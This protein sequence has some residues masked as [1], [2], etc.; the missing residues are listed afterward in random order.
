[1]IYIQDGTLKNMK[2]IFLFVGFAIF[3]GA[4]SSNG[5]GNA[6]AEKELRPCP[7][8]SDAAYHV[9]CFKKGKAYYRAD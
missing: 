9:P 2:S 5:G 4:C 3:L 8:G 6:S 1:M 7:Y